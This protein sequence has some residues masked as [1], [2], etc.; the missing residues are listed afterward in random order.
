MPRFLERGSAK[1]PVVRTLYTSSTL[2]LVSHW[3]MH[4]TYYIINLNPAYFPKL[5]LL[6]MTSA[7]HASMGTWVKEN[8]MKEL[9]EPCTEEAHKLAGKRPSFVVDNGHW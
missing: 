3:L 8:R 9:R 4:S 7:W 6:D 2:I 1:V 5:S